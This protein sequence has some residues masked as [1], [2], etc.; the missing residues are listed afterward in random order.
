MVRF[1]SAQVVS[2]L[3]RML[4]GFLVVRALEPELYGEFT[5]IGVF[6][7]YILLGQGGIIN[8]LSRELPYEL[9]QGNDDYARELASSVLVFSAI[10]SI[11]A[12]LIFAG[13]GISNLI[14]GANLTGI[15]YLAYAVIGGLFLF[16][17]QFLPALYR[18][19]KDFDSLSKQNIY[20]GLGNILS[21]VLVY[22]FGIY[23]LIARGAGLAIFEFAL[24]FKN[25]PYKLI[26]A[27]HIAHFRKL[28]KTGIPIFIIGNVGT[29][30]NTILNN[31][32]FSMGGALNY[33]LYG[34]SN[35]VQGAVGVIPSAFSQVV[36]PRMAIMLGEG[37]PV[38]QILAAN[39]KPLV[40]QFA[41]I[42]LICVGGA[43]LLPVV[44]PIILP[45]YSAGIRAAQWMMFVPVVQ[46]LGLLNNIYNVTKRQMWFLISLITGAIVGTIFILIRVN[47]NGFYL[48]VFPQGLLLGRGLSQVMSLTFMLFVIRRRW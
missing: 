7:G 40:F 42:S 17:K 28:F 32:I 33:G 1:A 13:F 21:V 12:S 19:N 29:L 2:N 5:G 39:L 31:M 16:N 8:G 20:T 45:K 4:A 47:Q 10:I 48:E 3:L 30:W 26:W 6:T 11:I 27:S 38:R 34:I 44:I 24:L 25:K 46:S 18:T 36:Y 37:K 9:G 15:I 22:I 43:L 35:I 23:G 14:Q 41:L